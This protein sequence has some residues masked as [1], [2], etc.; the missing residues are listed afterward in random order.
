MGTLV[1]TYTDSFDREVNV[2]QVKGEDLLDCLGKLHEDLNAVGMPRKYQS[3][4]DW[5]EAG[6]TLMVGDT[7]KYAYQQANNP[8]HNRSF[9]SLWTHM[10][11]FGKERVLA[12]L[13]HYSTTADPDYIMLTDEDYA[14]LREAGIEMTISC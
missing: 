10:R 7:A 3:A 12:A 13:P 14:K 8:A 6:N 4:Q 1:L 9:G 5:L 11:F 2:S